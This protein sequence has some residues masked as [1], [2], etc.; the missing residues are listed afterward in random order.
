MATVF[1]ESI[2]ELDDT[3]RQELEYAGPAGR[4]DTGP[5]VRRTQE[6]LALRGHAITVDGR[7]GPATEQALA[8]FQTTASR[9]ITGSLNFETWAVLTRA[10]RT[11]LCRQPVGAA[12]FR[13]AALLYARVH[14]RQ[15]PRD[16][17]GRDRG[18]WARLYQ[19]GNQGDAQPWRTR[20]A[21][22]VL[23]QAAESMESTQ[24]VVLSITADVLVARAAPAEVFVPGV[25]APGRDTTARLLWYVAHVA[26]GG[27][28]EGSVWIGA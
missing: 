13:D 2:D 17:G 28:P 19:R 8:A 23:A 24:P 12:S 15:R 6:W 18:P 1:V 16:V 14:L 7:F 5:V 25:E 3:I 10:M 9:D 22:F 4:G 26:S 20:F 11:V 21:T 27:A